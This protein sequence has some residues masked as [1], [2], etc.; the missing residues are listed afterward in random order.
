ML[1]TEPPCSFFDASLS[2]GGSPT[3]LPSQPFDGSRLSLRKEI[4]MGTV[5][6]TVGAAFESSEDHDLHALPF[7]ALTSALSYALDL[8]EGH[9]MGHVLRSCVIG[10]RIGK[11][12][13]LPE[14]ELSNLYYALLLKDV[15]CGVESSRLS[16]I[17]DI[18]VST[19]FGAANSPDQN[20]KDR[21]E[22]AAH[23]AYDLDLPAAVG[24][25]IY[26]VD[27]RWD[28]SGTPH[29]LSGDQI[30]LIAR[31]IH[32][33]QTLD[34]A[35]ERYG[36][37]TAIDIV[38]RRCGTWFD[39]NLVAASDFMQDRYKLCDELQSIPLLQ[40]VIALEPE[41]RT[42]TGSMFV[43]DN[44]CHAF[45]EVVDAKSPFTFAH[46]TGVAKIAVLIAESMGKDEDSVKLL[47]RAGL[48][49]DIGKLGVPRAILEKPAS[50][51]PMEWSSIHQHPRYTKQILDKIPGF[52][53]IARIA[54]AH[55][56]KLDGSGYPD[57]LLSSD[58]PSLVR[59]LTVA[60]IYE[61]LSSARP[62]RKS[63][64]P[65]QVLKLMRQDAPHALDHDVLDVLTKLTSVPNT[66]QLI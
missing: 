51:T 17:G 29:G 35:A 32:I 56:E 31:I 47:Q 38:S 54:S 34:I 3:R 44:I 7:S 42:L 20:I 16:E 62:Y 41:H 8:S 64:D 39:T 57:G 30:S 49:H 43:V 27:E 36:R 59:I 66:F 5:C 18:E 21:C 25:A 19:D 9:P 60:D 2:E 4:D 10:M 53:A 28:G 50:L 1:A 22:R 65:D 12:M 23:I 6:S 45:A 52:E 26:Q 40:R 15:G 55:H 58:I 33:A 61:A 13:Q 14:K 24:E 11:R 63:L 48:L 37:S 46:S